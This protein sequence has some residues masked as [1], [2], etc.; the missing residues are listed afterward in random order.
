MIDEA[1]TPMNS[2][3]LGRVM[4]G[5][6]IVERAAGAAFHLNPSAVTALVNRS[7]TSVVFSR[8]SEMTSPCR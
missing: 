2:K 5:V 4:P 3:L 8:E 7:G 6:G 1:V